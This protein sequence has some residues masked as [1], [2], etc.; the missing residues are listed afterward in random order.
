EAIAAFAERV[1]LL[2]ETVGPA[3]D[4]MID[5]HGRSRP[6]TAARLM[7]ALSP[8]GLFWFEEATQPDDLSGL[9]ALRKAGAPMDLASGERLYSKW[10]YRP[11]L[12]QR[13]VDVIQPDLC[14][15][16]GMTE[17]K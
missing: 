15:A 17:C 9:Q 12:E 7:Q 16:G 11:L 6:S 5:N 3:V 4:I 1:G 10:D 8:F 2:R 14:N 13:L